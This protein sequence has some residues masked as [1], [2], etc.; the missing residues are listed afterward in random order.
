MSA[1]V[2]IIDD[3]TNIRRVVRMTLEAAGYEVGEAADGERGLA[4]FQDGS[5]WD[6]VLLDQ[7]MPGMDGLETLRRIKQFH[8]SAC[9]IMVTAFA[10]IEL[11]VDAMKLGATDFIRKPMTPEIVRNAVQAAIRKVEAPAAVAIG[12]GS[13]VETAKPS[14]PRID[15]VTL[16]GFHFFSAAEAGDDTPYPPHERH[17]VV[18]DPHAGDFR[19]TVLIDAESVDYVARMTRRRLPA[20][21]SFW[22]RR[23]ERALAEHLWTEGRTPPGGRLALGEIDR[24]Q[25]AIAERWSDS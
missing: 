7:K 18:T 22:T 12:T 2:L 23:A 3:E 14:R 1:R 17:F 24:E 9:V 19:V 20:D 13:A 25:L 15:R 16:N 8:P 10:S 5:R 6:A 11:A 21:S 4:A